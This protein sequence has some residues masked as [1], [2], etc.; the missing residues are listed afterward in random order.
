MKTLNKAQVE[1][2]FQREAVL[3]E[4]EDVVPAF[5][6]KAL[7]GKDA[8]E[9]ACVLGSG[10]SWNCYGT[11]DYNL[12]YLTLRGF[13]AAASF[14]NVQQLRQESTVRRSKEEMQA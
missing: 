9:H 5:R 12:E 11:G 6:V 10:K 13:Q 7:F 3:I 4:A 8:V 1:A 2:M 14:Y